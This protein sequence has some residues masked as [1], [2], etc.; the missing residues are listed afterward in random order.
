MLETFPLIVATVSSGAARTSIQPGLPKS[1][2]NARTFKNSSQILIETNQTLPSLQIKIEEL[3]I[4]CKVWP[5]QRTTTSHRPQVATNISQVKVWGNCSRS[6]HM[7]LNNCSEIAPVP[8]LAT[9]TKAIEC[10]KHAYSRDMERIIWNRLISKSLKQTYI[11]RESKDMAKLA[12]HLLEF[13]SIVLG[14]VHEPRCLSPCEFYPWT[15]LWCLQL[16]LQ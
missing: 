8:W 7:K 6:L 5:S 14:L 2:S 13:V 12:R 16:L 9:G 3:Y 11:L 15:L 1:R 4:S 10:R